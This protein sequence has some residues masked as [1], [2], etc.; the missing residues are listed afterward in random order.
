M[1]QS[2]YSTSPTIPKGS[3]PD[4]IAAALAALIK[5]PDPRVPPNKRLEEIS[6]LAQAFRGEFNGLHAATCLNG[7]ALLHDIHYVSAAAIDQEEERRQLAGSATGFSLPGSLAVRPPS[8]FLSMLQAVV[9][10]HP[11][12]V[13]HPSFVGCCLNAFSKFHSYFQ[14]SKSF[15]QLMDQRALAMA[16]QFD[17]NALAATLNGF[18][19]FGSLYAPSSELLRAF[20]HRFMR[21]DFSDIRQFTACITGMASFSR[22]HEVS[23]DFVLAIHRTA[24]KMLTQFDPHA[25]ASYMH[26]C[27]RFHNCPPPPALLLALEQKSTEFFSTWQP[28]ELNLVLYGFAMIAPP[29]GHRMRPAFWQAFET[30]LHQTLFNFSAPNLLQLVLCWPTFREYSPAHKLLSLIDGRL[31]S[32][33]A[34][35]QCP[36]ELLTKY[37]QYLERLGFESKITPEAV[38]RLGLSSPNIPQQ[39]T[40]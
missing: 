12:D 34:I 36:R 2:W 35:Q 17:S 38:Q 16:N 37:L 15:F 4:G 23:P 7:L 33:L 32:P 18:A 14:P 26:T 6:E 10:S 21:S 24:N 28:T 27:A 11:S 1:G 25:V 31:V 30:R 9:L 40:P 5:N 39:D 29:T 19:R 22:H 8:A 3:G 13:T 20:E